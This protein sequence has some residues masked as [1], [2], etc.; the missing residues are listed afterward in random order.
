LNSKQEKVLVIK[1]PIT[2]SSDPISEKLKALDA[3][4]VRAALEANRAKLALMNSSSATVPP[5]NHTHPLSTSKQMNPLIITPSSP[6]KKP[7]E[8]TPR[9]AD[10]IRAAASSLSPEAAIPPVGDLFSPLPSLPVHLSQ[11]QQGGN[12]NNTTDT[13]QSSSSSQPP[14]PTPPEWLAGRLYLNGSFLFLNPTIPSPN[15]RQQQENI[16][17]RSLGTYPPVMQENMLVDDMLYAFLGLDGTYVKSRLMID[18]TSSKSI[19]SKS[20]SGG[21]GRIGFEILDREQLEPAVYEMAARMLPICNYVVIIQRYIET[22]SGACYEWGQVCQALSGALR[23]L[24]NDWEVIVAQL[25]GQLKLGKLTLQGM[26]YFVQPPM[27]ALRLA[28]TLAAD[29]SSN[30]LRGA[31]LLDSLSARCSASAGDVHAHRL[32]IRLLRAAAEPYFQMLEQWICNGEVDDPWNEFMVVQDVT[33]AKDAL[34]SDGQCGFWHD[35]YTLRLS[36]DPVHGQPLISS[37]GRKVLHDVPHFLSRAKDQILATGKYLNVIKACGKKI[38]GGTLSSSLLSSSS[39]SA[40]ARFEYDESS[41]FLLAISQ[42][43][44]AASS[45]ALDLLRREVGLLPGLA[46]LKRYFLTSQGDVLSQIMDAGEAEWTHMIANVPLLQLQNILDIAIRS[47]SAAADPAARQLKAAMDHRSI[48][49]MLGA[50]T[51]NALHQAYGTAGGTAGG[52]GGG[53][54]TSRYGNLTSPLKKGGMGAPGPLKPVVP[55]PMTEEEKATIGEK[56]TARESFMLSYQVPWPLSIVAPEAS[57][58][59]YQMVFKHLF[60]LKWVERELVRVT[61]LVAATA[62]LAITHRRSKFIRNSNSNSGGGKKYGNGSR[63]SSVAM[64]LSDEA[65]ATLTKMHSLCQLTNHFFRQYLL[66]LTFEVLEPLWADFERSVKEAA[67]LDAIVEQHRLFLRK[68]LKGSLLSRKVAVLK[69]MM[70]LKDLALQFVRLSDRYLNLNYDAFDEEA[71][72]EMAAMGRD[73]RGSGG[74][75]ERKELRALKARIALTQILEDPGFSGPVAE[76]RNKFMDS[77]GGF[78]AA[79]VETHKQA[80]AEKSDSREELESL[81]NLVSRLDYNSW[82]TGREGG[83]ASVT[84]AMNYVGNQQLVKQGSID[85]F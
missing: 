15:L 60:E 4:D 14:T 39:S 49:T 84:A 18:E 44:K 75:R 9:F 6:D 53:F 63:G 67:D 74:Q 80:Q 2:M 40:S 56:R 28:A 79:L 52:I 12:K 78:V 85:R 35:R 45:A 8:Y 70:K 17:R 73:P 55:T 59:Q 42:A 21:G 77:V 19:S 20:Q 76:L 54:S 62:D 58:A 71:E 61:G 23:A 81:L 36:L 43:H 10:A 24:L 13:P 11:Q 30:K 66:Y 26:W 29:A 32:A 37:D 51:Q 69:A 5:N 64:R 1:A 82:L 48:F 33:V 22:R 41:R 7:K 47:S 27:S 57:V 50:I 38:Q 68:V 31:A 65:A 34:T 83:E 72:N 25:E 46:T 16:T 3:P